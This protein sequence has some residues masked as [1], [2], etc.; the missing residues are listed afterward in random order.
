MIMKECITNYLIQKYDPEFIILHGSRATNNERPDSDWD[1][2]VFTT[3][4]DLSGGTEILQDQELDVSLQ[5]LPIKISQEVLVN[6]F[7]STLQNAE[8][9][10]DKNGEGQEFLNAAKDLYR[11]SRNLSERDIENRKRR[12]NRVLARLRGSVNDNHIFFYHSASFYPSVIR[13][14][15]EFRNEWSMPIYTAVKEIKSKD[16]EYF[17]CLNTII[18]SDNNEHILAAFE[19]IYNQL[20]KTN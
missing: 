5:V 14:W 3:N 2:Y 12:F 10:F 13:Y 1:L 8:I 7:G 4:E 17:D 16:D 9:L 11:Q 20:F 15:F 18:G 19:S 6:S